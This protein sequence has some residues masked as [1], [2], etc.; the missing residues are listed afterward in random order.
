MLLLRPRSIEGA[1]GNRSHH[2][3]GHRGMNALRKRGGTHSSEKL[4]LKSGAHRTHHSVITADC[5]DLLAKIP[6]ASV[7]L[8][9]CDP[10]YNIR[11]AHWDVHAD[12]L[13]WAEKWLAE[14]ERV[15]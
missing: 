6:D 3:A 15:L 7:Q 13:T 14:A 5:L 4:V 11:L 1:M 10:P 9:V 8:I 2:N 12:Y